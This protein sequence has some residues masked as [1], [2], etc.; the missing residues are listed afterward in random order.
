MTFG[1]EDVVVQGRD[2]GIVED[3]IQV[4]QRLGQKVATI[5]KD[6]DRRG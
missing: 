1:V 5:K 4:L 2:L 6:L 3:Q